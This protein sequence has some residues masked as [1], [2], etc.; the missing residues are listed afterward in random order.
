MISQASDLFDRMGTHP[1]TVGPGHP[2]TSTFLSSVS[3]V[4]KGQSGSTLILDL[5]SV[6]IF[7]CHA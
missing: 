4:W 1:P 6:G 2:S 7:R 5:K 3:D